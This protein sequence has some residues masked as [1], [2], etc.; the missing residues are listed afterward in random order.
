MTLENEIT[1]GPPLPASFTL[2]N[3]IFAAVS[4]AVLFYALHRIV[5]FQFTK[6]F[7]LLNVPVAIMA[8]L[9][10]WFLRTYGQYRDSYARVAYTAAAYGLGFFTLMVLLVFV[11]G[12]GAII[13]GI[14]EAKIVELMRNHPLTGTVLAMFLSPT[15]NS[16]IPIVERLWKEPKMEA[17][18][19]L[20]LQGS[21]LG[22]IPLFMLRQTG[23]KSGT[24]IPMRMYFTGFTVSLIMIAFMK[25]ITWLAD[26]FYGC[27]QST[28]AS[29]MSTVRAII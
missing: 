16:L 24:G 6:Q 18:M 3:C 22:S 9:G 5:H 19:L 28:F 15:S 17:Y 1:P 4:A 10:F 23:F 21:A 11:M 14:H 12:C 25:P 26:V 2:P 27:F 29:L 8:I 13:I 7:F 20:Y